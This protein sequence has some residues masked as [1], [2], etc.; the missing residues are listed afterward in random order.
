MLTKLTIRNFKR[1]DEVI[2]D[3]DQVV[4]FVGP[5]N[6]GKTSALQA[7]ALWHLGATRWLARRGVSPAPAQ[8]PGV[9][10]NRRDV[11]AVPVPEANLLW[12]DRRTRVQRRENG[13]RGT[14]NLRVEIVVEGVSGQ[15]A[16]ICPL[17]FDYANPESIYCRPGVLPAGGRA[18]LPPQATART[19]AYLQPMSGLAANELRLEPGAINVRLGEGRTAEVLRNLCHRLAGEQPAAWDAVVAQIEALFGA[20]LAAPQYLAERGELTMQYR[21]VGGVADLDLTSAGRG[22]QQTLLL[23]TFLH[24]HQNAVLLLDEPDAHL[25]ILRQ[26]RIY[27]TLC[28]TAAASGS[29]VILASHSEVVLNEAAARDTVVA[30]VGRP[31]AL[32]RQP[33]QVLKALSQIGFEDYYLATQRGWVLYL[34][35]TTDLTL[36]QALARAAQHPAAAL[37]DEVFVCPVGREYGKATEHFFGLREAKP[38]LVGMVILDH[39]ATPPN[40]A[41]GLPVHCWQRNELESYVCHREVLLRWATLAGERADGALFANAWRET[42]QQSIGTL[43]AALAVTRPETDPWGPAI[44]ASDDFLDPLLRS[45]SLALGRRLLLRKSAYHELAAVMQPDE[46][47][48]EVGAVLDRLVAVAQLA[49]PGG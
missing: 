44:K 33:G 25:E 12:R 29:Q 35:G 13:E 14:A 45:F 19:V 34:E 16:W 39:Q 8:R 10:L 1:L 3:L 24:L 46:I 11:L 42:M 41:A 40:A 23:L 32:S 7:L 6:C 49:R 26:R 21:E 31:H 22:L 38:D 28:E 47:A 43:I 48:P 20:R 5:N 17:E 2:I 18:E 4:V 9:T 30:F 27:H 37:L 36:L 15:T